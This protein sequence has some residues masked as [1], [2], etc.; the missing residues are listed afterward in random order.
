MSKRKY[1]PKKAAT[2]PNSNLGYYG[3]DLISQLPSK[4]SKNGP[5]DPLQKLGTGTGLLDLPSSMGTSPNSGSGTTGSKSTFDRQNLYP[6]KS[7]YADMLRGLGSDDPLIQ[8]LQNLGIDFNGKLDP[9]QSEEWNRALLGI[10][11]QQYVNREQRSY[12]RSLQLDQRTY[13]SPTNQLARLMGAGISRDAAIQML[14]GGS[15]SSAGVP[16]GSQGSA[17]TDGMAAVQAHQANVQNRLGVVNAIFNGISVFS[18]LVGLGFSIPQAI[19]QTQ[20]LK[21]QNNLS[22]RQLQAYDAASSAYNILSSIGASADAFGSIGS[23]VSAISQAAQNGDVS[24][25]Q[26]IASG[27]F[28]RLRDNAPFTSRVMSEMYGTERAASDY[29]EMYS[30][31][32]NNLKAREKLDNYNAEE[33]KNEADLLSRQIVNYDEVYQLELAL[34]QAQ[35][36]LL[37]K[38]GKYTEAQTAAQAL[39]NF[40]TSAMQNYTIQDPDGTERTGLQLLAGLN[41]EELHT[42]LMSLIDLRGRNQWKVEADKTFNNTSMM[43]DLYIIQAAAAQGVLDKLRNSNDPNVSNQAQQLLSIAFAFQHCGLSEYLNSVSQNSFGSYGSFGSMFS[44]FF[45]TPVFKNAAD[46]FGGNYSN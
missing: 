2:L 1:S 38:Q 32:I 30:Q 46:V 20:Y 45:F 26:F 9:D 13:D 15:G 22:G 21:N 35:V 44:G 12:D 4:M 33:A 31:N 27:G 6:D 34:R 39:E 10:V 43:R 25:Q 37:R 11:L 8:T 3:Q 14:S 40:Q 17:V 36:D 29:A 28:D 7:S 18:S 24:A 19:Q 42:Q 41:A 23:A 16:Y 5:T